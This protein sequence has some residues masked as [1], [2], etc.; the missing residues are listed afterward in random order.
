M[1]AG[2][3]LLVVHKM[4]AEGLGG[5][6][7]VY[8]GRVMPGPRTKKSDGRKFEAFITFNAPDIGKVESKKTVIIEGEFNKYVADKNPESPWYQRG[9]ALTAA[10]LRK[11]ARADFRAIISSHTFHPGDSPSTYLAVIEML[12]RRNREEGLRGAL[13][14]RAVGDGDVSKVMQRNVYLKAKELQIPIVVTTQEPG[15]TSSFTGNK[16]SEGV[17]DEFAVIPAWDMSIETMVVKLRYLLAKG[18]P[19]AEIHEEFI[20]SYHGE[21]KRQ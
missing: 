11:D 8:G 9:I 4:I 1:N 7:V 15:G 2:N 3:A 10:E 12:E 16:Q 5:V 18:L 19:Y 21:I 17:E 20:R 14:I 13:I 6:V